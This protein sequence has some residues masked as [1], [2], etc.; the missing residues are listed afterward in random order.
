MCDKMLGSARIGRF[1]RGFSRVR[2]G[3]FMISVAGCVVFVPAAA[4][5]ADPRRVVELSAEVADAFL[6][7]MRDHMRTLDDIMMALADADFKEVA[8]IADLRLDFGHA[9]WQ[10]MADQG[11]D[12]D[13]ILA[14]KQA[15]RERGFGPGQGQ[16]QR[17]GGGPGAGG[18]RGMGRFMPDDF[19]AMGQGFHAA[20]AELAD[21]ARD[22]PADP[23]PTDY[24]RILEAVRAVTAQCRACHDVFRVVVRE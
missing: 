10:S 15:M 14:M 22:M 4:Q 5:A 7:E 16:G 13:Q 19:R 21:V 20:G 12:P 1:V 17:Q 18:G 23:A 6:E 24:A 8:T 9:M 3:V 2:A 11:V